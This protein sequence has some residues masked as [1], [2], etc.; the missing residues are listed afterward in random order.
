MDVLTRIP[1]LVCPT[2]KGELVARSDKLLCQS[3]HQ[4]LINGEVPMML[5]SACDLDFEELEVQNRVAACYEEIRYRDLHSKR[6][7]EWWTRY[8]IGKVPFRGRVLDNGC[9]T[10]IL[11]DVW[12]DN[13]A[14][15]IGIDISWEML[16]RAQRFCS[17]VVLGTCESLP[18]RSS[19]FDVVFCRGV[20][21]H[22]RNAQLAVDEIARV[23][24]PNGV[25]VFADT[26]RSLLTTIPRTIV[27]HS[28]AFT[29][30]HK[31]MSPHDFVRLLSKSF[32]IGN[33]EYF[34][35][36]AYVLFGFPDILHLSKYLPIKSAMVPAMIA[37]DSLIARMPIL[38][39]QAFGILVTATSLK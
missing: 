29:R 8:M 33:I 7:H 30:H 28:S 35:F 27:S 19:C 23:L 14:E 24:K 5:P 4:F 15:I 18:F 17:R 12:R 1:E 32:S 11:S 16:A 3:G 25:A 10:G 31:N 39:T 34:G 2:C 13:S 22:L 20:L 6:Y 26:N 9:G 21:H 36:I 38:R 37:F